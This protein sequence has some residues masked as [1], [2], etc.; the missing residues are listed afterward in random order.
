MT[1]ERP[2]VIVTDEALLDEVLRLAA[3]T[4]CETQRAPDPLSARG[5][6]IRAPLVL[7]DEHALAT[8]LELPR[9]A[10]VLLI[11]KGPPEAATWERAFAA[12]V[13]QVLSLPDAEA[14]LVGAFADVVEGPGAPGGC[15]VG[16]LGGRGGAG[17]SVF[18]TALA[19]AGADSGAL[20]VDCDPLGGGLD[21][22]LG[23]EFQDGSRW[24][25]LRLD[26]G[27]VAMPSLTEALPSHPFR[28][29]RLP[30]VSCEPEGK[31]PTPEAIA[32]VV[33][34][35]RRAGRLVVCDLP[36][37]FDARVE[38]VLDRADLLALVVPAEIRA[39]VAARG[40]V[41]RIGARAG[42]VRLVVR[43]PSPG[44]LGPADVVE[45]VKAPLLV[46]MAAERQLDKVLEGGQF[47]FRSRGPLAS[48]AHTALAAVRSETGMAEVAA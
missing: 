26:G 6:W 16:V 44:G 8:G 18:A 30:F 27:R 20:L 12:G 9:R 5:E 29:G 47:P 48:A 45:A 31:E 23:A 1:D 39:C 25:G 21:L 43:G 3:A 42:R 13:Q 15:V 14:A 22:L 35:G 38:A 32:S 4:G 2:L 7:V 41:G 17:A 33:D 24:S 19:L 10:G 40:L 28:G 46:S 34:A 11:T 37:H 36:R